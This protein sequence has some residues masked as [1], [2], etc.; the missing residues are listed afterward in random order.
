MPE[1]VLAEIYAVCESFHAFERTMSGHE[2]VLLREHI[3]R[4]EKLLH[5][6]TPS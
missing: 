5:V 2:K 1:P 3:A 6:P 4:L